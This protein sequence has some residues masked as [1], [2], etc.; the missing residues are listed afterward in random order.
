MMAAFTYHHPRPCR[1]PL[2]APPA[3][4][5][6]RSAR[7]P[8]PLVWCGGAAAGQLRRAP[9]LS[10]FECRPLPP[11]VGNFCAVILACWPRWWRRSVQ[12]SPGPLAKI[13]RPARQPSQNLSNRGHVGN[14]RWLRAAVSSTTQSLSPFN[15]HSRPSIRNEAEL[16]AGNA[17]A[18]GWE[19]SAALAFDPLTRRTA[20]GGDK[21]APGVAAS[22]PLQARLLPRCGGGSAGARCEAPPVV[23]QG[24]PAVPAAAG[25]VGPG[26][27]W[28][29]SRLPF[30]TGTAAGLPACLFWTVA[31]SSSRSARSL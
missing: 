18:N 29:R 16:V 12:P 22:S 31:R 10:S 14:R 21:G 6:V 7:R 9:R 13:A 4:R 25:G 17:T 27:E 3:R 19:E 26:R 30:A 24:T 20:G 15:V 28:L 8:R 1:Q 2:A 11:S 5:G 23:D